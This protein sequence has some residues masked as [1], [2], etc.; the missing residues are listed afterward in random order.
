MNIKDYW[1]TLT[2]SEK[3][4]YAERVGTTAAYIQVHLV[5]SPPTRTP[6]PPLYKKLMAESYGAISRDAMFAYFYQI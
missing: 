4:A 3:I 2:P 5:C 1:A 6:R